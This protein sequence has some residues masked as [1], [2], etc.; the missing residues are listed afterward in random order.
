MQKPSTRARL[1][2]GVLIATSSYML[3][4]IGLALR[5]PTK[6]APAEDDS[7]LGDPVV[8]M[9]KL[10]KEQ[11]AAN[12]SGKMVKVGDEINGIKVVAI[13]RDSVLL[14]TADNSLLSIPICRYVIE[15]NT[16][17]THENKK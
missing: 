15:K 9:I 7:D 6:P 4:P 8:K 10:S 13:K 16:G 3:S 11:A 2:L 12:V 1:F 17:K 14:R 5:D